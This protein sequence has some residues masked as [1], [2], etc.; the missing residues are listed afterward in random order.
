MPKYIDADA[1]VYMLC[2]HADI[3]S[4]EQEGEQ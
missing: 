1:A 3:R 2:K 4:V